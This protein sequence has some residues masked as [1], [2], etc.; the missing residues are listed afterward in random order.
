MAGLYRRGHHDAPLTVSLHPALDQ[1]ETAFCIHPDH[2]ETL[3]R[4]FRVTE[5][6]RHA[7]A[8]EHPSGKL[9]LA[10]GAR[11]TMREG[12]AVSGVLR[13]EMVPLDNARVAF[14]DRGARDVNKLTGL[15]AIHFQ[16]RAR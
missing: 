2:F 10:Y 14:A 12:I 15:K 5:M 13:R 11:S 3:H 8:R 1:H 9:A 7:L 4:P 16:F 6:S